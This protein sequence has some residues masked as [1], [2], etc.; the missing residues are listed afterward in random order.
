LESGLA[1]FYPFQALTYR[2]EADSIIGFQM[3]QRPRR[4]CTTRRASGR[5]RRTINYTFNWFYAELPSHTAY[6]NSG[7]QP[8]RAPG[9]DPG[10]PVQASAAY[11]WRGFDPT[12]NTADYT[13]PAEHP[14]SVDQDYY[15]SWNNNRRARRSRP[16]GFGNGS[17]HRGNCSTTGSRPC[18]ATGGKVTRSSL[19]QAMESAALADLRAEDGA[20]PACCG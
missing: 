10:L 3:P 11:E 13:P 19:T 12:G 8:R 1:V 5:P 7:Q 16:P 15:I 14:N 18:S 2:H 9:V 20:A 6:Y 4:V 17:V